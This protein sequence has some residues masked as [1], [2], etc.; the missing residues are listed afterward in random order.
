MSLQSLVLLK[1]LREL[2]TRFESYDHAFS[3][4]RKVKMEGKKRQTEGNQ[5]K[6]TRRFHQYQR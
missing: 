3:F 6:R 4:F 2:G 1:S 5:T